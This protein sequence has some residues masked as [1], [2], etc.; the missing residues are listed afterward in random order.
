MSTRCQV[1]VDGCT[2]IIYRHSN[3]YPDSECG[4]LATLLPLVKDFMAVRGEDPEYLT[5]QIVGMWV[6]GR[7]ADCKERDEAMQKNGERPRL[8]KSLPYLGFGVEAWTGQLHGDLRYIY[9][10]HKD[11]VEVREP[12]EGFWEDDGATLDNTEVERV[13]DFDGKRR[14]AAPWLPMGPPSR[15]GETV[16]TRNLVP[17]SQGGL[18]LLVGVTTGALANTLAALVL[19]TVEEKAKAVWDAMTPN[20]RAGVRFGMFPA[21]KMD[22]AEKE[23]FTGRKKLSVALMDLAEKNGGMRA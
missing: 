5:A 14:Q 10:V 17:E 18:P 1:L 13:V 21:G 7:H 20:E 23:G 11:C 3:G 15:P 16:F 4:V 22:A 6:A 12:T 8:D 2:A 9:I 19:P